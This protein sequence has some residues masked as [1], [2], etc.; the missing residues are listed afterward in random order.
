M[1]AVTRSKRLL[2]W[3][4]RARRELPWREPS[5]DPYRI[6]VSEVMLQ[7]TRVETVLRYYESFL[8]RFPSAENLAEAEESEVLV[9]WSG[10]GYYGRARKLHQ[11][12]RQIVARGAFPCTEEALRALPGVGD[13]T[14]A[15]VASI[16]FGVATPVV[17]GN[18]LRVQSRRLGIAQAWSAESRRRVRQAAA[19]LVDPQRPGD[20]NQA[21][22]ELGATICTPRAPRCPECPLRQGCVAADEGFPEAYPAPRRRRE[23]EKVR[24]LAALV[25]DADARVLLVRRPSDTTLL[26]DTWEL[27]WV[28]EVTTSAAQE[29][30]A[31]R[32][33]GRWSLG[34]SL[35]EVRHSI[36]HR[37]LRVELRAARLTDG[38]RVGEGAGARWLVPAD[39]EE[40]ARSSLLDKLLRKAASR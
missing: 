1:A 28:R 4:D 3:F 34:D 13:Y 36:T 14:A 7:Q 11:A 31:A 9:H 29:A 24:L 19:E 8:D 25:R 17:D 22:M 37:Q 6:L 10:L 23:S 38:E 33:G 2:A 16:G 15:A 21:M 18:V 27:P 5:P 20:S 40:L 35:G 39:L 12:A 26:A 32:Y 30:L